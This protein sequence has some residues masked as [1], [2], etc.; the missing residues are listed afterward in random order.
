VTKARRLFALSRSLRERRVGAVTATQLAEEF[1]VSVRTIYRDMS[2]LMDLGEPIK[3]EAGV[4][5]W[6]RK[7]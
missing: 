4:G 7:E 1:S 5:Y 6:L 3:S 2:D